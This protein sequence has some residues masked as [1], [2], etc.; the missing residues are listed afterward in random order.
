MRQERERVGAPSGLRRHLLLRR[1]AG[2]GLL[3]ACGV[4]FFSG[5]AARTKIG[6]LLPHIETMQL[7]RH[8]FGEPTRKNEMPGGGTRNEWILDQVTQVPGQNVEQ[9]IFA[10]YDRDGFP[11]YYTRVFFVPAH[12]ARQYCRLEIVADREEKVLE[13]PWE[14]DSCD[15]LAKVPS[16]Y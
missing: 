13:S 12:L 11:V 2:L 1:I 14:G 5:C 15:E 16:T 10:G 6:R 3:A 4:L 8:Y 7:A 9:Q